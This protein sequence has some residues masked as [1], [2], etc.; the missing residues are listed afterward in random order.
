M[1]TY[2]I[3]F[4][5]IK[6]SKPVKMVV[7]KFIPTA[8]DPNK[9]LNNLPLDDDIRGLHDL[10]D[11]IDTTDTVDCPLHT[12]DYKTP[13]KQ[14]ELTCSIVEMNESHFASPNTDETVITEIKTDENLSQIMCNIYTE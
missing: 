9:E 10:L 12:N 1:Y 6:K 3:V 8:N 4:L 7:K 14:A 13:V 2:T 5:K 11:T